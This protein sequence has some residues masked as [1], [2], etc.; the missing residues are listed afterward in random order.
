[1]M[2]V[3][4]LLCFVDALAHADIKATIKSASEYDY[5][6]FCTVSKDGNAN[7]FS[8]ELLRATLQRVD[9]DVDF[10]VGPWAEVKDKLKDG[11]VQVLP[12]VG[13]TPERETIFD[14]TFTYMTLHGAIF[15][16]KGDTRIKTA[17]D[18]S[19]KEIIVMQGDNAE[20]YARRERIS[21]HVIS[22]ETYEKAMKMLESGKHDAVIAQRLM[23]IQLLKNLGISEIV[24]VEHK[25]NKFS[26]EF[27]FAVQEG[28]KELLALLNEG[29]SIVMTDG[30][31]E[32][33][34]EKWF[35]PIL[36]HRLSSKDV[37][38]YVLII[39]IPLILLTL[40]SFTFF[41]R[42]EVKR[43]TKGLQQEIEE[44]KQTEEDK[45]ILIHN[46]GERVKELQCLYSIAESIRKRKTVKEI[47]MDI[48]ALIPPGWHYPD[49]TRG[50]IRFE[51]QNYVT[52]PFGETEWRQT[53]DILIK[54]KRSGSVDVYYLEERPELDEGPFLSEERNL[55]DGIAQ[56]ISEAIERKQ[57]EDEREQLNIE[58]ERSNKELEQ[59]AYMASHDLKSPL[60]SIS[61]FAALLRN[62]YEDKLDKNAHEYIDF[63]VSSIK[64]MD[65]L[66]NGLLTYSRIGVGSSKLK[67]VD[68]NK[69][70]VR[71]IA[72]LTV[73]IERNKARITHDS[74]PT[75]LGNDV[76]LEQLLQNLVGNAIKF[77]NNESQGVHI[78]AKQNDGNWVFS[79]KD[80][81][82]GIAP[83]NREKIFDMF[84]CLDRA[85]YK[86]T[87]I[88]LATCKKIVELH[89]G[90]IWVE[91]QLNT[92]SIFYFTM[93]ITSAV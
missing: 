68:V 27:S 86:G 38:K 28:D 58:L 48:L 39:G 79:V 83:E 80:N 7:G 14:F 51:G 46:M 5:P 15:V 22:V 90:K 40:L 19:D 23:G 91:S 63:I 20:E 25:L 55:I 88:G 73:D 61:G 17:D 45:K 10:E 74:L 65:T 66:I 71:A 30:T 52:E 89:G 60:V 59:F 42:S 93:P 3:V 84:Q 41:L 18:L 4:F 8:V 78:S 33:L 6:P 56:N 77:H 53:S 2:Y 47:F 85:K 76:Q 12:L 16:R 72:N 24:P 87:G 69:V 50:K 81:G 44:R 1:M 92:G 43:K 62:D 64:R 37:L 36:G 82:I 13:R 49:I 29:L 9:L 26:Q 11:K 32:R 54:G 75:V 57:A 70:F 31:F 34:Y 21:S 67:I 35:V